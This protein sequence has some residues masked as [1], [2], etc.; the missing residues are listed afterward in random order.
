[1]GKTRC[2]RNLFWDSDT[3][4]QT[5]FI[6]TVLIVY[7]FMRGQPLA[8]HQNAWRYFF[9]EKSIQRIPVIPYQNHQPI[10]HFEN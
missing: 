7:A 8:P 6:F 10:K 3:C 9:I 2:V 1:M 4:R 5:V